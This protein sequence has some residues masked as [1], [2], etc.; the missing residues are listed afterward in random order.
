METNAFDSIKAL[1]KVV[2]AH[3]ENFDELLD[4]YLTVGCTIF[5]LEVGIASHILGD[6]Y[7][8]LAVSDNPFEI[9]KGAVFELQ[10]T[11]CREVFNKKKTVS[12]H[13]AGKTEPFKSHPVYENLKLESYISA[14]VFVDRVL[15]GTIN[16]SST[17]VR[18]S[19]FQSFDYELIELMAESIGAFIKAK[20]IQDQYERQRAQLFSMSKLSALGKMAGGIAHE[21]NNPLAIISGSATFAETL[22]K[23][24]PSKANSKLL[25][26]L[27]K[28]NDTVERI[29][30]IV[31]GMQQL[32]HDENNI[33]KEEHSFSQVL[34]MTLAL[35]TEK[36]KYQSVELKASVDKNI[37]VRCNATQ[38]SQ[39]LLNL[40]N[41]AIDE[42]EGREDAWIRVN[43]FF[44]DSYVVCEVRDSGSGIPAACRE[45]IFEP[46]FTTKEIGKGVGLGLSV[47]HMIASKHGGRLYYDESSKNTCFVLE[48]PISE[49]NI[50]A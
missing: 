30:K 14:P 16:F 32:L 9:E 22:L 18:E 35:C 45:R 17:S 25:R 19:V 44:K 36:A 50:A 27:K 12:V 31:R 15:Y 26:S 1:H 42:V 39:L 5:G 38:I 41:N 46:F 3:Y 33:D 24:F 8:V 43:V 13:Q 29:S 28:V 48:L 37:K 11:Y 40:V 6:D 47:S 4:N 49:K 7:T 23:K 10:G 21:I 2:T 20:K 34:D